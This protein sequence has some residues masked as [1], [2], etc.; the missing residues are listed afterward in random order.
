MSF[1]RSLKEK[2]ASVWEAGY[3][4]SFVQELGQGI[5]PKTTFQFY[6]LQDYQ[7]LLSYAKVFALAAVKSPTEKLMSHFTIVQS[8]ILNREMDI[9]RNYMNQ[10]GISQSEIEQVKPALFNRTYT[11]NMLALGETGG[12]AEIMASVFPCAWTYYDYASRLKEEY[13]EKL[14]SNFYKSWIDSY[15]SMEFYE[16]FEWFFDTLDELCDPMTDE[17]KKAMEEIFISSVE[18]EY[19]FWDMS[20]KKQMSF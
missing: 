2:A 17:Q 20:Y 10:F 19:L 9:H 18:F 13:S 8:N 6:L 16:S 11:A 3:R 5:L 7:Y 1:S 4:H 14:S 15:A 12:L